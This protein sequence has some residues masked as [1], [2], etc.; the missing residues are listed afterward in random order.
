M[1]PDFFFTI[2]K[3]VLIIYLFPEL[4]GEG[5][6]GGELINFYSTGGPR[7]KSKSLSG[8]YVCLDSRVERDCLH[9]F[10]RGLRGVEVG[11]IRGEEHKRQ[12]FKQ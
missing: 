9:W 2:R 6:G 4:G 5:W 12:D 3:I 8:D 1:R 10:E 7:K 11:L